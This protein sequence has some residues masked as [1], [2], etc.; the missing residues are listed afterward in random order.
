M[1]KDVFILLFF[2]FTGCSLSHRISEVSYIDPHEIEA[3]K[4]P[5]SAA[6]VFAENLMEHTL[7]SS[8]AIRSSSELKLE[9]GQCLCLNLEQAASAVYQNVA[10]QKDMPQPGIFDRILFFSLDYSSFMLSSPPA[11]D[12]LHRQII[13]RPER[14]TYILSIKFQ[15]FNGDN[16]EL[17]GTK[18][19]EAN[20][21]FLRGG[22][23]EAEQEKLKDAVRRTVQQVSF[24]VTQLLFSG[25]AEPKRHLIFSFG[26]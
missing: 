17:L 3:G 7:S 1:K 15:A 25:F 16:M 4:K 12:S 23:E 13:P 26:H 22:K 14:V 2:F 11:L 19:V 24:D 10:I 5:H 9:V 21:S 6:V 20:S 8:P 18:E